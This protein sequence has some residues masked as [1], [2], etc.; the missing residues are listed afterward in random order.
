MKR[1][2]QTRTS[3]TARKLYI[4]GSVAASWSQSTTALANATIALGGT[5]GTGAGASYFNA[6]FFGGGIT[7]ADAASIHTLLGALFSAQGC[8]NC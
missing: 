8:T 5:G 4:A 2:Y 3:T 6:G 7:D 1:S